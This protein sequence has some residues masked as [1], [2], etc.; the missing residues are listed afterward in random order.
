MKSLITAHFGKL[1]LA[2]TFLL[3]L[4]TAHARS[5]IANTGFAD[6]AATVKYLGTQDDMLV[7]NV[8]YANPDGSRF[9]LTVKDQDGTQLYQ[10]LFNEKT[11]YKQFRLPKSDKDRIVFVFRDFRDADIVKA[12]DVNVNSRLIREVAV[13][14][15]N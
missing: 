9:S 2:T 3:V 14:Q 10:G 5:T 1:I 7:F 8:S 6:T 12:F 4:T 15:I 13:K 11:F